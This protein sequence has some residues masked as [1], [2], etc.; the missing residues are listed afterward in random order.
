MV[1]IPATVHAVV[2]RLTEDV[3]T[4]RSSRQ[5]VCLSAPI[6]VITLIIPADVVVALEAVQ[7]VLTAQAG[8]RVVAGPASPEIASL[9]SVSP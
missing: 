6:D 7:G 2:P 4:S 1:V 3:V 9:A 8:I 5:F